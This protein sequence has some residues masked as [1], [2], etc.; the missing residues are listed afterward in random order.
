MRKI[1]ADMANNH[2]ISAFWSNANSIV[3]PTRPGDFNQGV[4]ELG[5]T[6]C[7]PKA[8]ECSK[9]PVKK[10]CAA[11]AAKDIEDYYCSPDKCKLC[12]PKTSEWNGVLVFPRKEKKTKVTEKSSVVCILKHQHDNTICLIQRPETGLLANLFELPSIEIN[13]T[14]DANEIEKQLKDVFGAKV[15]SIPRY[16]GE[17]I[18]KFSHI[19]QKYLI[20]SSM[21]SEETSINVPTNYQKLEWIHEDKIL[22]GNLAISTAMK[23]VYQFYINCGKNPNKKRKVMA[24]TK[25]QPSILNF[26]NK[27]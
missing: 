22:E 20:W 9:C 23:K 16:H 14:E 4:M 26:F 10:H 25:Q 17:I 5:A 21:L 13:E 24:E 3:S 15:E 6:V 8:P 11:K 27:K 1:G 18:H 19:T 12:L 7:S 2:T